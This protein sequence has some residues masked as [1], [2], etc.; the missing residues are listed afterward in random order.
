MCAWARK[1]ACR[2]IVFCYKTSRSL[3]LPRSLSLPR[4][5]SPPPRTHVFQSDLQAVAVTCSVGARHICSP[6]RNGN[7]SNV[8][9]AS[10]RFTSESVRADAAEVVKCLQF[11]CCKPFTDN[12]KVVTLQIK[13]IKCCRRE[14]EMRKVSRATVTSSS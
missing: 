13:R 5:R 14:Q 7:V 12:F 11:A 8:T 1:L 4:A 9:D 3:P 10:Q 2:R 6:R